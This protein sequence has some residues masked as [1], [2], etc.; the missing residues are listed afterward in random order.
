MLSGKVT[1]KI[2]ASILPTFYLDR[3]LK[4]Y[5]NNGT[6]EEQVQMKLYLGRSYVTDGNYDKAMAI[7]INAL[8]MAEKINYIIYADIS[9][10]T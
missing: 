6:Q 3:A 2:N 4:W 7:Y 9:I 8:E 10:V 1:D 5:V